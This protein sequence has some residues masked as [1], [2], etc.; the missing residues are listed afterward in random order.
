MIMAT[1]DIRTCMCV[2]V[3]VRLCRRRRPNRPIPDIQLIYPM[4]CQPFKAV[5]LHHP[6]LKCDR[7]LLHAARILHLL[8]LHL[9]NLQIQR[10]FNIENHK[11]RSRLGNA[12]T[13][14]VAVGVGLDGPVGFGEHAANVKFAVRTTADDQ[15]DE[16]T[17]LARN[18]DTLQT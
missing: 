13:I 14:G 9:Y 7:Q 15:S 17:G 10:C 2:R 6:V 4:R 16:G 18:A 1:L 8:H 5:T 12:G 11:E 3:R